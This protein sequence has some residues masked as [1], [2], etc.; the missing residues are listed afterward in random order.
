MTNPFYSYPNDKSCFGVLFDGTCGFSL[1]FQKTSEGG[2]NQ[3]LRIYPLEH[4]QEPGDLEFGTNSIIKDKGFAE[5]AF[6]SPASIDILIEA[7]EIVKSNFK[8]YKN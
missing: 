7:L 3:A 2:I 5:L 1:R 4:K 8:E 6:S